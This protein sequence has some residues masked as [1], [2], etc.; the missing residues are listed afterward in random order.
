MNQEWHEYMSTV[1]QPE[2]NETL[3]SQWL[4]QHDGSQLLA[5]LCVLL[6]ILAAPQHILGMKT[7]IFPLSLILQSHGCAG[8]AC[9]KNNNKHIFC[10]WTVCKNNIKVVELHY[11]SSDICKRIVKCTLSSAPLG[12]FNDVICAKSHLEREGEGERKALSWNEMAIVEAVMGFVEP[13]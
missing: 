12:W 2:P 5:S 10:R 7:C 8:N 3:T 6:L 4:N 11:L 13:F 1:C 9:T